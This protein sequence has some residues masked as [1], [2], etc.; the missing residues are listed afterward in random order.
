M[1]TF[2]YYY[3]CHIMCADWIKWDDRD[4]NEFVWTDK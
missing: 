4:V 1:Y 2:L 3:T